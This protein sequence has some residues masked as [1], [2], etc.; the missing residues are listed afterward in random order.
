MQINTVNKLNNIIYDLLYNRCS[1]YS[2]N[3]VC[4]KYKIDHRTFLK[5]LWKF[6]NFRKKYNQFGWKKRKSFSLKKKYIDIHKIKYKIDK[7]NLF[8]ILSK[9][10]WK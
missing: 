9:M 1:F 7:D 2:I 10:K 4:K 8:Y 6:V 3:E 5:Y